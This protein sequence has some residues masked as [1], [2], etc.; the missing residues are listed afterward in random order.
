[1]LI[2]DNSQQLRVPEDYASNRLTSIRFTSCNKDHF[3]QRASMRG[4]CNEARG[5]GQRIW[6]F[7]N[8]R[9]QGRGH[10]WELVEIRGQ[11]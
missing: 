11:Y 6:R 7:V 3:V 2:F 5:G 8:A 1:M 10:F 9:L 4:P